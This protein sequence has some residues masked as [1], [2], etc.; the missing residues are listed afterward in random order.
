MLFK[1][2]RGN[3]SRISTDVTPWHDGYA[4]FTPDDGGFYIDALVGGQEERVQINKSELSKYVGEN[5]QILGFDENGEIVV[6]GK[7]GDMMASV[8]D[9]QGKK[10]DVFAYADDVASQRTQVQFVTWGE[11]D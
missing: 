9:P 10:Q 7:P 4:Y 1:I 3:S 6:L 8:Y 11:N 2:L 5:G